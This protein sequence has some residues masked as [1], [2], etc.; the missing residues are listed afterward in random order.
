M[1]NIMGWLFIIISIVLFLGTNSPFPILILFL[2][3]GGSI[4][5]LT[6]KKKIVKIDTDNKKLIMGEVVSYSIPEKILIKEEKYSQKVHSRAQSTT[7]HLSYYIAYFIADG[8]KYMVSKNK[9][10]ETDLDT[11]LKLGKELSIEVEKMY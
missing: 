1:I 6:T 11:L 7:V 2:L 9:K 3:T 10:L 8:E 5:W 4:I